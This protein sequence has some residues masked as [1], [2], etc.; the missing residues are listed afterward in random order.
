MKALVLLSVLLFSSA[1]R[2]D[3]FGGWKYRSPPSATKEASK[4]VVK[5]TAV[6]NEAKTFCQIWLYAARAPS[7]NDVDKEWNDLVV[8][9]LNVKDASASVTATIHGMSVSGRTMT[10]RDGNTAY[11]G[12]FYVLQPKDAVS[13]VILLS[14]NATSLGNCPIRAF[15]DSLVL[16]VPPAA[17]AKQA[18]PAPAQSVQPSPAAEA[19][20]VVGTWSN[21]ASNYS[22]SGV[23]RGATIKRQYTFNPDGT[24]QFFRETWGGPTNSATYYTVLETGTWQLTGDQLA[25]SP[26]Q[27]TGTEITTQTKSQRSFRV[28]LEP[29]TYTAKSV[30]FSGL[31]EWNLVLTIVKPTERDGAFAANP[32]YPSSYL[33]SSRM[34]EFR[35]PPK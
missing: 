5:L 18:P 6:D 28:P 2:A 23:A 34:S 31:K 22:S 21:G 27:T 19:P 7:G 10:V 13:S 9:S 30:Y 11:A 25:V 32:S 26:K 24:Y 33:F 1:A 4:S 20:T 12:A 3:E 29:A 17:A 14:T 35:Y 8:R 16:T 15:L